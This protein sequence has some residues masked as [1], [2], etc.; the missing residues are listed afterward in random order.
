MYWKRRG[1]N[2]IGCLKDYIKGYDKNIKAKS[3]YTMLVTCQLIKTQHKI[4]F[5]YRSLYKT[6]MLQQSPYLDSSFGNRLLCLRRRRCVSTLLKVFL[7]SMRSS[8]SFA[9]LI[10]ARSL[11]PNL[12]FS[13][14]FKYSDKWWFNLCLIAL[15]VPSEYL[16]ITAN[17]KN[18][19]NYQFFLNEI[20]F[21][22][23][24]TT[25]WRFLVHVDGPNG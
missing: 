24:K 7:N 20:L 1:R 9:L 12:S 13:V 18:K 16:A 3:I 21:L 8:I 4:Q 22:M 10:I 17:H 14:A 15:K 5:K 2:T 23:M 19:L 6:I 11:N 25:I